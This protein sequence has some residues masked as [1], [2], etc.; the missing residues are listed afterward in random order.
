MTFAGR[1]SSSMKTEVAI[2]GAGPAGLMAA[3]A[4]SASAKTI[5]IEA[6]PSPGRKLLRTGRSR[7][8][9]THAGTIEEFVRA[10]GPFAAFLSH[11]LHQF[12]PADLQRYL[13][14]HGLQTKVERSGCIF[15]VSDRAS[16]VLAVLIKD[17]ERLAVRFLFGRRVSAV[18]KSKDGFVL[19]IRNEQVI[20]R[21]V[22]IATGGVTWPQTG[23][24]GDG[25]EFAKSLG[26]KVV[27]PRAALTTL[28]TVEDWPSQLQG[29]GLE[30]VTIT[31]KAANRRFRTA[32][33]MMFTENGIGGP[34]VFDLSRLITDFLP[35]E[36]AP[37][38]V[39]VDLLTEHSQQ[40]LENKIIS[41]CA[42]Y[43]KKLL[44]SIVAAFLPRALA[45]NMAA[46]IAPASS[47]SAAHLSKPDRR[48]LIALLKGLE[49]SIKKTGPISK[50]T[51]T[52]GGVCTAQI[53]SKTMESKICPGLFF[54]GE[55]I[56]VD[57]PS[58]GYNLQI[59]FSTGY[60]AGKMAAKSTTS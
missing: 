19:R 22:V 23:S 13:A 29:V 33:A 4:S 5:V 28:V 50:A 6:N 46:R 20:A 51:V 36:D 2:I 60:L 10:Y 18:E 1:A 25:Y 47:I 32:G 52:R 15:P 45:L 31:A 53:N 41:L 42:K 9:L 34:A 35:A 38:K 27:Q 56:N 3:I 40:E 21:S 57:G 58:G 11:S 30:N 37:I 12:S 43:P 59:A 39:T 7:C 55:V 54:A 44:E 14:E 48:R 26:H 49:L 24:T 16:D 17:S 8:N